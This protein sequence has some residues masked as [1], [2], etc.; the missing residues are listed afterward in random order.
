MGFE[1]QVKGFDIDMVTD[2]NI[3][4]LDIYAEFLGEEYIKMKE[5]FQKAIATMTEL[6]ML[7]NERAKMSAPIQY[8]ELIQQYDPALVERA[9]AI[10][11]SYMVQGGKSR[12]K[13]MQRLVIEFKDE[14]LDKS[15][16]DLMDAYLEHRRFFR[17]KTKALYRD[18]ERDKKDL[19]DRT[20]KLIEEEV[21]ETKN[22]L[23]KELELFRMESKKER[24]H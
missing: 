14:G 24:K 16:L 11:D 8:E 20:V 1:D 2:D 13:Y 17:S 10:H 4:F 21:E 22:R 7:E 18:W 12:D 6:F 19:K 3:D 23:M 15:D 9:A 5:N